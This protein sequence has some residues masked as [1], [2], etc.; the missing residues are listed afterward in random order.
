[1]MALLVFFKPWYQTQ[2]PRDL[3][4]EDIVCRYI[5]DTNAMDERVMRR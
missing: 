1:M 2:K 5:D 3:I 4:D